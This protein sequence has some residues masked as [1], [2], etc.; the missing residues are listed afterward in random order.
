MKFLPNTRRW[1]SAPVHAVTW[2]VIAGAVVGL[3]GCNLAPAYQ[4]PQGMVAATITT[5]DQ[6]TAVNA[7]SLVATADDTELAQALHWIQSSALRE[8]VALALTHNRDL[9]VAVENIEKARAQ[10]GMTRADG[11]PSINAQ[12]QGSR[13]RTPAEGSASV[14]SAVSEQYSAQL[15]FA[16]Y[17]LDLWGRV[18][19]LNE[20]AL[21]QF[22]SSQAQRHNVQISLVADV[23]SAWL[24][25]AADMARLKLAQQT[26]HSRETSAAMTQRMLELGAT[27]Q[28][29]LAQS[30]SAMEVAR[31]DV[32]GYTSQMQRSLHALQ[33]LTGGPVP[34]ALLP[35]PA[36]LSVSGQ[37]VEVMALLPVPDSVPSSV[38]LARPDVQMAEHQ[39]RVMNANIGTARA[40]MFPS[41]SLTGSVGRSSREL[42]DLFTAGSHTWNF[43]PQLRLPIFDGGRN[44]A[45]V[46]VAQSNQRM[47]V[48]QYEK[49]MQ[50]AFREVADVLAERAQWSQR[51][52]AQEEAVAAMLSTLALSE[53]RFKAGADDYLAVLDAQRSVYAAQ[54]NLISMRLGEQLNRVT[55]WKVLGGQEAKVPS[56]VVQGRM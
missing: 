34:I 16:S 5:D 17:E 51:L 9:R 24:N 55:L 28:I 3:A 50:T 6:A 47:A 37:P 45:G 20:A 40:A 4:R 53:A 22:L 52:D 26:L 49:T 31:G 7:L 56:E 35:Q 11:L 12:M 46:Q 25:L 32:A 41:I 27:S 21:Q 2:T 33:W 38:L 54:Q 39:L 14:R 29:A 15:G 30:R 1:R 19:N 43:M 42:D 8:V 44:R 18:R 36:T 23:G 13:S 10:Y 48:A